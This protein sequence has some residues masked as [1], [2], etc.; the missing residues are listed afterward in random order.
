MDTV[1]T[2][3]KIFDT[4][5]DKFRRRTA[6]RIMSSFIVWALVA[7]LLASL[8]R[9]ARHHWP[10]IGFWAGFIGVQ[11]CFRASYAYREV[12]ALLERQNA[13]LERLIEPSSRS[14]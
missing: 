6:N 8:D 4:R 13:L 11:V 12:V 3:I 2:R 5:T 1:N 9:L 14:K 10:D 7:C